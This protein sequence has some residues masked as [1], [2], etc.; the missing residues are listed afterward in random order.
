MIEVIQSDFARLESETTTAEDSAAKQYETFMND[1]QV[2]KAQNTKDIEHRS[3]KKQNNEQMLQEAK[4]DLA[5]TQKELD[6]ALE[7]YGKL[8]PSCVDAGESYED[9][10]ARRKE[11][12][13][14]LQQA[15]SILE[16]EDV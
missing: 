1:S 15:L 4:T 14:S 12:I 13:D 6:A 9:R 8:K 16:G 7:Y 2:A 10:V 5:G 3:G 11:E